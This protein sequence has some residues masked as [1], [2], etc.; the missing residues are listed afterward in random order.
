MKGRKGG[1][2]GGVEGNAGAVELEGREGEGG[3]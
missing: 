2:R 3:L 1:R